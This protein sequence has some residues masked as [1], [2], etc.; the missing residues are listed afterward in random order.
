MAQGQIWSRR[1]ICA[2]TTDTQDMNY[3]TFKNYLK[4]ECRGSY[5]CP[6]TKTKISRF[7]K[8]ISA[9]NTLKVVASVKHTAKETKI[10]RTW[11]NREKGSDLCL[12]G[13]MWRVGV[14]RS[15]VYYT[16]GTTCRG[17]HCGRSKHDN[18]DSTS[19]LLNK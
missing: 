10:S 14:C 19:L 3:K 16:E 11:Q 18:Y 8:E 12:L 1:V 13:P 9:K 7:L 17:H 15:T 5:G 6:P 2:N 4:I